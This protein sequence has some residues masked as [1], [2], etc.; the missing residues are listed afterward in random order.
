M[1]PFGLANTPSAFMH[2]MHRILGPY[3]K[4]AVVYLDG[5]LIFSHSLAEH[6]MHVDT[7]LLAIRAAH[8]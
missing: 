2:A 6:K 5:M 4:F 8:L 7:I 3:K 1:I